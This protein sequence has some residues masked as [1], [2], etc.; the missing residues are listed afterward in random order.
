M[1]SPTYTSVKNANLVDC[2]KKQHIPSQPFP[3]LKENFLGEYRTEL[4]KKK[5]LANLGIAT[6]LSLEW[7]YI[8]GDIGRSE[9]LMQE[10]DSRTKYISKIDGFQKTII[11][12]IEYL[13]TVIGG[14][15]E[16]EEEQ[17]TRLSNL[18]NSAK[19]LN[20]SLTQLKTYL[21]S[22]VDVNIET[23][24]KNLEEVTKKVNNITELI[25][26]ST[27]EGNALSLI[28]EEENPGLYV[29]DLSKEVIEATTNITELQTNVKSIL[30]TY[31]T[32]EELGGGDFDFV[33]QNDFDN[34]IDQTKIELDNITTELSKTVKTGEDGHVDTLYVNKISKN[35][36]EGNIIITN[37]LEVESNK[38]LD[39]RFVVEDLEQLLALPAD[40]C[41]SGM[42]VIVNSLSSLY[43]LRKPND[44]KITQEY[45]GDVLNWKCP[46][47]LVTVALTRQDY[48]NLEEI[49]PNV[50]YYIYE[51]E[52]SITKEPKR[53]EY[54]TEEEFQIAWQ[55]WTNS[56]KILSQE[57]M[58]ASWGVEIENKV[59]KKADNTTILQLGEKLGTL[60]EKV[61]TIIGGEGSASLTSLEERISEAE[62]DLE[63][64][65]GTEETEEVGTKGKVKEIEESIQNLQNN[66]SSN[67][68]TKESITDENSEEEY[69]FVKKSSFNEYVN[70]HNEQLSQSITTQQLNSESINT[71]QI[72]INENIINTDDENSLLFNSEK[73]ALDKQV[74]VIEVL[75]NTEYSDIEKNENT[76]YY[77]YDVDKSYVT[78][79]E[80]KEY[81]TSQSETLSILNSNTIGFLGNL[82]TDDKTNIVSAINE[83]VTKLQNLTNE[84]AT[85]KEKVEALE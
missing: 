63:Y 41:Y 11:Q 1:L 31:V 7:E 24:T 51:N 28:T 40:T 69:I 52:V 49:N 36:N 15:Q 73:V 84:V 21:E 16:G 64:L 19:Q 14:E 53:E 5:V 61:E 46:E 29:P 44:D 47:D 17:N 76:Y 48:E 3:L 30:D 12:G 70:S 80:F 83:L 67:Y 38:P 8:K 50:F 62:S 55:D 68:V 22:T 32:K 77:V 33:D 60:E 10:L 13:E 6:D 58:S 39:I 43:I 71:K 27:K 9:S 45:I 20:D 59:S 81:K 56:L 79:T 42:G 35:N 85:L 57:Y 2:G 75:S 78:S 34:Y 37:S 82:S 74:P 26:V 18:E 54:S 25:Q 23:L 65:L 4:D 72:N 66:I